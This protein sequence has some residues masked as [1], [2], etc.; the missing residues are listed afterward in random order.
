MFTAQTISW[1]C[2]PT[3]LGQPPYS[4]LQSGWRCSQNNPKNYACANIRTDWMDGG[5]GT[6]SVLFL[7]I[8]PLT[9]LLHREKF[10]FTT[11]PGTD[12]HPS[13]PWR[14]SKMTMMISLPCSRQSHQPPP[15]PSP[16]LTKPFPLSIAFMSVD[17]CWPW[18]YFSWL[19]WV[20][21]WVRGGRQ[22]MDVLWAN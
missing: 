5:G 22:K 15:V 11:Y 18:Y 21:E 10:N 17:G 14:N 6:V 20:S 4:Y 9:H 2:S 19:G 8:C 1:T 16:P 3:L 13:I 7:T 12:A